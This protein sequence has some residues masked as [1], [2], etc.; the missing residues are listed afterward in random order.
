MLSIRIIQKQLKLLVGKYHKLS[1][2]LNVKCY[3]I[4]FTKQHLSFYKQH[5]TTFTIYLCNIIYQQKV[6]MAK[7]ISQLQQNM[8]TVQCFLERTRKI[9]LYLCFIEQVNFKNCKCI[10]IFEY[11]YSNRLLFMVDINFITTIKGSSLIVP[12]YYIYGN[13]CE[14][15][16]LVLSN[17]DRH[18]FEL[19]KLQQ[20]IVQVILENNY[21]DV[22][23]K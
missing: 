21:N 15:H 12:K 22:L 5:N 2:N 20:C 19:N 14:I 4:L 13:S 8:D 17:K 6:K 3:F 7:F 9:I 16:V 11:L 23:Q 10:G 18:Y 1:F